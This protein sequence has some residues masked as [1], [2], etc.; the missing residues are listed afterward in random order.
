MPIIFDDDIFRYYILNERSYRV[1]N[2]ILRSHR[3][4]ITIQ[5]WVFLIVF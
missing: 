5:Y 2:F 4:V 1:F 3:I